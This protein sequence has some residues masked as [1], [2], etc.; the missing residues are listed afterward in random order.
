MTE[1]LSPSLPVSRPPVIKGPFIGP[2]R[3]W[4]A[5]AHPQA[6]AVTPPQPGIAA[7]GDC[8]LAIVSAFN[9]CLLGASASLSSAAG[10]A[11]GGWPGVA[12]GSLGWL[13]AV[14]GDPAVS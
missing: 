14:D 2:I 12:V 10:L 6:S 1:S 5:I 11:G 7:D 9:T 8:R 13:R 3:L 4:E